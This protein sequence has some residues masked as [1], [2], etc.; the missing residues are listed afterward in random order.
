M[1][2]QV[3]VSVRV[4]EDET[5]CSIKDMIQ[6]NSKHEIFKLP[7]TATVVSEQE[8]DD[9]NKKQMEQTGKSIQNSRVREKLMRKIQEANEGP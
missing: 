3:T 4:A 8:F 5:N 2:K 9:L 7:I 1:V 6:I